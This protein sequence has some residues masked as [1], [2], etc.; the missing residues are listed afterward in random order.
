MK[1]SSCNCNYPLVCCSKSS[2][3]YDPPNSR[4]SQCSG[5]QNVATPIPVV[6]EEKDSDEKVVFEQKS[7]EVGNCEK[8]LKSSLKKPRSPD[9]EQVVKGNVKWMD[10]S[11]KELV[12][13]K[14]FELSES[15]EDDYNS[16]NRG[17]ICAIQ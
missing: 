10:L 4:K 7:A 9:P 11:G 15:D 13:I 16:G 3:V 6:S 5:D 12:E 14:E 1:I 17:S 8:L 2:D